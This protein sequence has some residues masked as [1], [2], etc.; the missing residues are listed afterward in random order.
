MRK[1]EGRNWLVIARDQSPGEEG[2]KMKAS[3]VR[4]KVGWSP[5]RDSR[6]DFSETLG[7]GGGVGKKNR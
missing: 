7:V 2:K 5:P 1:G 4:C 6:Q 3:V